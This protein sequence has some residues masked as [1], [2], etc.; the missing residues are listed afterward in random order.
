MMRLRLSR[1]AH[2]HIGAEEGGKYGFQKRL[3]FVRIQA[4]VDDL[5]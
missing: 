3:A 5:L 4:V 2:N 1:T